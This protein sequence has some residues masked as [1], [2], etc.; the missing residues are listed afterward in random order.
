MLQ[1]VSLDALMTQILMT[2]IKIYPVETSHKQ[3][4]PDTKQ[5]ICIE[6]KSSLLELT[7]TSNS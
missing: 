2:H 5:Q 6:M 3:Y 7:R 1:V 4:T